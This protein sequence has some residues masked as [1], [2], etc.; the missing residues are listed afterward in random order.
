M[1]PCTD[2]LS[3]QFAF[4]AYLRQCADAPCQL[5]CPTQIDIKSFISAI[6]NK[7]Y[8]AA[9]KQILSDNPVGL[10]CGMVCPTSDLCVGGCNA[11][12]TE[13]GAINIGGLQHFA[14][15]TFKA[16]GIPQQRAP[17]TPSYPDPIAIV[18]CG[19]ASVSAATFLARLGYDNVTIYERDEYSGGLSSS[20]IPGFR[21]PQDA[22]RW[23]VEQMLDLGVKIEYGKE[24]GKDF[25]VESLR[26]D[27][28]KAVR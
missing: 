9:A 25:T 14:V 19:P 2:I 6:A 18:G 7:N 15:E 26:A 27:G 1:P 20:E 12:A 8:Y 4:S 16:M 11:A 22:V 21:L 24:L 28:A 13:G 3:V 23:E 5:S 17:G 10:S